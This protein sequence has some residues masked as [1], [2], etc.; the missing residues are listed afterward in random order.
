MILQENTEYGS[1]ESGSRP[2]RRPQNQKV[3][4]FLVLEYWGFFS[5]LQFCIVFKWTFISLNCGLD[6][7]PK[8]VG[9][10]LGGSSN[11]DQCVFYL[12]ESR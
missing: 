6:F 2:S 10:D 7:P 4:S 3:I 5:D 11:G 1:E 9:R 8:W 12:D